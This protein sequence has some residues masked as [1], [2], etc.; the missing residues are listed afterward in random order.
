M[1]KR[2]LVD[3]DGVVAN[4]HGSTLSFVSNTLGVEHDLQTFRGW[5]IIQSVGIQHRTAI[6]AEWTRK[7]WCLELPPYEGAIEGV[8]LLRSVADVYFVTAQMPDAPYWMYERIQWL[9]EHLKADERHIVITMAKHLVVGD[10]LVDD[11]PENINGWVQAHPGKKGVLWEQPY[12]AYALIQTEAVRSSS[13][14]EVY[15]LLV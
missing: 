15:Q 8:E 14:E 12:N 5:D 7:G 3:I 13:W 9:K 6:E 2:V 4:F 11:K 10:V 1:K